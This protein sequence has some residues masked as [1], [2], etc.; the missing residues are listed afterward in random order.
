LQA[1]ILGAIQGVTEFLPISSSGHLVLYK[2][3]FGTGEIDLFFD[4]ILHLGTLIAVVIV[5]RKDVYALIQQTLAGSLAI[6]KG[7][8]PA[9]VL[10]EYPF[11]RLSLLIVVGT[12]PAVVIGLAFK[13]T[14]EM[15]FGSVRAVSVALLVTGAVLLATRFAPLGTKKESD[16]KIADV[17]FI[18][19]AQ[20][21]AITPGISRSGSTIAMAMFCKVDRD[22]AGR[23]S[24]L[25]A[26]PAILGAVV[27]QFRLPETWPAGYGAGL[28]V[29]LAS[30]IAVGTIALKILI[31]LVKKG[32]FF[33]FGFYCI[34]IGCGAF[35]LSWM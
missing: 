12:I 16:L 35:I 22:L 25:L 1:L 29:G 3:W 23:F 32:K 34:P 11:L 21:M 28:L 10:R 24:F 20:A 13:D 6:V 30:A 2:Q 33:Y 5:L 8:K 7:Q 26:I 4:T 31:G 15:L 17:I 19:L 9:K 27:L 18:G 14:F